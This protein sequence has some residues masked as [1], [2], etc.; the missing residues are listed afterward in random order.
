VAQGKGLTA[1][2]ARISAVM[3][4][5]E[6]VYAERCET[7]VTEVGSL[8]ELQRRGREAV[9]FARLLRC[10]GE[11]IDPDRERGG[12]AGRRWTDGGT[13][14]APYELIGIDYR[15]GVGWDHAAFHMSSIGLAAHVDRDRAVLHALL[16]VIENDATAAVEVFGLTERLIEA[17]PEQPRSDELADALERLDRAGL[18]ARF[19]RL[20]GAL[21]LP[22]LGCF[23]GRDVA[24]AEGSG[25]AWSA[26]FAC[27]P[28]AEAAALAA[29][30]EAV[31]S[32]LTDIAGARDDILPEHFRPG[33]ADLGRWLP[34]T[35]LT[36]GDRA[37][38]D[39]QAALELVAGQLRDAGIA[40][41]SVFDLCAEP[42][43]SVVR[44]LVPEMP[45]PTAGAEL[46]LGLTAT[47]Q[48]LG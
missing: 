28:R 41:W 24:S 13:V 46:R 17:A 22:V 47:R 14:Y 18:T 11:T 31:Q 1:E 6:T 30:L 45:T 16:E 3:E 12:V 40:D 26:G 23:V 7:L 48:L 25:V 35:R 9:E 10:A 29:L 20:R 33:G 34:E 38:A 39:A 4:S 19:C 15:D 43:L 37:A 32:R 21:D 44:V 36:V 42:G 27:R 8:H 2:Q 5:I